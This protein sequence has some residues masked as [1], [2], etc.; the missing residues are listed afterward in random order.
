M[1]NPTGARVAFELNEIRLTAQFVEQR[2]GR[3]RE[4]ESQWIPDARLRPRGC[5]TLDFPG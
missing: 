5:P 3:I 1:A 2:L 4:D